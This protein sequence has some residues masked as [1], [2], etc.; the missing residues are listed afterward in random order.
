MSQGGGFYPN[1]SPFN[2]SQASPGGASGETKRTELSR[3][4]RP[5]TLAQVNKAHQAHTDA[6]WI[7]EGNEVGQV[8]VIGHVVDISEQTTNV[9]YTLEDG[10]G[11]VEARRWREQNTEEDVDKWGDIQV[12]QVIRVTGHLKAFGNRKYINAVN[13]R[14]SEDPHEIYFHMM[15]A[16]TVSLSLHN[17][18]PNGTPIG[19]KSPSAYTAQS[20]GMANNDM[21]EYKHLPPLQREIIRVLLSQPEH[22]EGGV[23]VGVVAKA[24]QKEGVTG[25]SISDALD[26]L[27]DGGQIFTTSDDAHFQVSR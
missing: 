26:A 6:E 4:V 24:V 9:L 27:M 18:M 20:S 1:S 12:N 22:D 16:L 2:Q 3:S 10:T 5:L 15:D 13:I 17:G 11:K 19:Q 7:L 14:P 21:A 23:H 8:T 25:A